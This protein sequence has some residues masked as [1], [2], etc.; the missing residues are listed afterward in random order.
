MSRRRVQKG[1]LSH[2]RVIGSSVM[3]KGQAL[4]CSRGECGTKVHLKTNH[5]GFRIA[6]ELTGG[7]TSDSPLFTDLIIAGPVE[8]PRAIF[9]DKG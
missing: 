7:E 4:D 8:A 1:A 9:A 3:P 2:E 5:D 6:F